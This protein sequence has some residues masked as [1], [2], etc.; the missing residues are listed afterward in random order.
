[1]SI[2]K[3]LPRMRV[4][5]TVLKYGPCT[6]VCISILLPFLI[7]EDY[8]ICFFFFKILRKKK[9]KR[10]F[11]IIIDNVVERIVIMRLLGSEKKSSKNDSLGDN[12]RTK[13]MPHVLHFDFVAL[14][15]FERYLHGQHLLTKLQFY[16]NIIMCILCSKV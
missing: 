9:P 14:S 15:N 3:R 1:M 2:Q 13:R 7:L 6:M 8:L 10:I 16:P 4:W 12:F 5:V 11:R